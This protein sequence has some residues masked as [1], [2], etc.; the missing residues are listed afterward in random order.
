MMT[1][2]DVVAATFRNAM[3]DAAQINIFEQE[4]R[5]Y[6]RFDAQVLEQCYKALDVMPEDNIATYAKCISLG[7]EIAYD[8]E[9]EDFYVIM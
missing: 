2:L 3:F 9:K 4:E 8:I 6:D 7:A 5:D 1:K